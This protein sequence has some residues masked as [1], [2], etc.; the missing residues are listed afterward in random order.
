V[1]GGGTHPGT[2]S[3][4]VTFLGSIRAGGRV[5]VRALKG[6]KEFNTRLAALG[7]TPGVEAA[8]VQNFGR[9]PL[10]VDIR[11]SR[12]A[13]GRGEALKVEVEVISGG[14]IP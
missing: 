11:D 3:G 5:R 7:F 4:M 8:V 9:G 1:N 10:L 12:V 6:G 13:L 2:G 14:L